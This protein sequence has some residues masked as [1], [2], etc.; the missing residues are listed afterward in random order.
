[1]TD[2]PLIALITL[3][4]C[5]AGATLQRQTDADK[6]YVRKGESRKIEKTGR[7][8]LTDKPRWTT[9]LDGLNLTAVGLALLRLERR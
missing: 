3:P 4:G 8:A 6:P 2:M 5:K 9:R 1:M 7:D